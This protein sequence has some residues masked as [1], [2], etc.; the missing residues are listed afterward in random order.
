MDSLSVSSVSSDD[1]LDAEIRERG[2]VPG[3]DPVQRPPHSR[4]AF[5]MNAEDGDNV[6]DPIDDL[7]P[8][9]FAVHRR[10]FSKREYTGD[11]SNDTS[12]TTS[13][14]LFPDSTSDEPSKVAHTTFSAAS[15]LNDDSR[16]GD[17]DQ[18]ELEYP[19]RSSDYDYPR[20][21]QSSLGTF[22]IDDTADAGGGNYTIEDGMAYHPPKKH[23]TELKR[24]LKTR[25]IQMIAVGGVL[26]NGLFIGSGK[27]LG[28]SGPLGILLGFL[29]TGF[30]VF[31]V[32]VS[33]GE[34][35][36]LIPIAG[37]ISA[38][39]SRFVDDGLGFALGFCYWFSLAIAIPTQVSSAAVLLTYF[40]PFN[41]WNL[42]PAV[43]VVV[44]LF[45]II[46][47]NS[48]RVQIYGEIEY[49]F[50]QIKLTLL[51]GLIILMF[52][53]NRGHVP[54]ESGKSSMFPVNFSCEYFFLFFS[55]K[56]LSGRVIEC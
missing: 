14:S 35:V 17:I 32:M 25:H 49:V 19:R 11:S 9:T 2:L 45:V 7:F 50:G 39:G 10:P 22:V 38:F 26:G 48:M 3:S 44:F 5:D 23:Y 21:L 18:Y 1:A 33:F 56:I 29:I 47:I 31:S 27:M 41:P 42:Y 51:L 43:M 16:S 40:E 52:V 55:C 30:I 6:E 4:F 24:T 13:A 12:H 53:L 46:F 36:A 15:L 8:E 28:N 54:P 34:M 37:G 20:S